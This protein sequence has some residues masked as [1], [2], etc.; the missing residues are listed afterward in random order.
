[1]TDGVGNRGGP[2]HAGAMGVAGSSPIPGVSEARLARLA[3][4]R[5]R[6][7]RRQ[8]RDLL[9]AVG[10][11]EGRFPCGK[12]CGNGEWRQGKGFGPAVLLS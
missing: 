12:D 3:D 10:R 1:M 2:D 6:G 5:S 4:S 9:G 7:V 11:P 8:R